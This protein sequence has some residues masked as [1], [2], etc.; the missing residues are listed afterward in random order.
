[1]TKIKMRLAVIFL[2]TWLVL[3]AIGAHAD[4]ELKDWL[5]SDIQATSQLN[6][7]CGIV[8]MYELLGNHRINRFR[9]TATNTT[10]KFQW[11]KPIAATAL[12]GNGREFEFDFITDRP[13][14]D[15][16]AGQTVVFEM[17]LELKSAFRNQDLI[18]I[19]LPTDAGCEIKTRM[20]RD[21]QVP[22]L[23]TS[24][25]VYSKYDVSVEYAGGPALTA[26]WRH[27]QYGLFGHYQF[28][29]K[30]GAFGLSSRMFVDDNMQLEFDAG[31]LRTY[32]RWG[33]FGRIVLDYRVIRTRNKFFDLDH[34]VGI[35]VEDFWT[36]GS[37]GHDTSLVIRYRIG[38]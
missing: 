8:V 7:G 25:T 30:K 37:R 33:L 18:E 31:P 4:S 36:S 2:N 20:R 27:V 13:A 32:A 5:L 1:M 15:I 9:V 28:K 22:F 6:H 24:A 16:D 14:V 12:F 3:G 29:D 35:G 26:Y 34:S 10:S 38:G 19:K 17:P 23:V 11:I 21:T